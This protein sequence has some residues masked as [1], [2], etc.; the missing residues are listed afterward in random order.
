MRRHM[1]DMML[2]MALLLGLNASCI[3]PPLNLPGEELMV[4]MPDVQVD[5]NVIWGTDTTWKSRWY[6]GWD[7]T[8]RKL[9]GDTTYMMP[10]SY[11]VR[12]YWLG[13][14]PSSLHSK[15]G[16]DGFTVFENSFRRTYQFGYYD[17]LVWSNIDSSDG[18]QVL[19]FDESDLDSV[20][21]TTTATRGILRSK[22]ESSVVGLYNR[23]EI[24]YSAYERNLYISRNT[25][26]YDYFDEQKNVWVKTLH[27]TLRPL[28]Y[29]YLV[30][31]ILHNNDAGLITGVTGDAALSAMASTTSVNTG[32]TGNKPCM[33][34]FP[35]RMK[36]GITARGEKVDIVGGKLTTFGL[37]DMEG[38]QPGAS[39]QYAG[40]RTDLDNRLYLT[41]CFSNGTEQTYDYVVTDQCRTQ[42]HGGII[43]I[44]IDC[45]KITPPTPDGHGTG[46]I[47]VPTVEDYEHVDYDI[48]M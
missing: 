8:D 11:E 22:A 4:Q 42:C 13:D 7:D 26:D 23:P 12:R 9:S 10:S 31:V 16:T 38:W 41:L 21:A 3:E 19:L 6:Y 36:N 24:F 15:D 37:C 45:S 33:V 27:T 30:Q 47:F 48:L 46:N 2:L 32:H 29:I 40:S 1:I 17:L 34:Y 28:V 39:S 18:T 25:A 5:L 43:T 20:G 35:M 44:D 14:Q